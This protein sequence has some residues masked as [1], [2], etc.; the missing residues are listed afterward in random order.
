MH[1]HSKLNFDLH[2]LIRQLTDENTKTEE[3]LNKH[4]QLVLYNINHYCIITLCCLY[5]R[6]LME[7]KQ[8]QDSEN[9]SLQGKLQ[10]LEA[11][12]AILEKVYYTKLP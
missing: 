6:M 7:D 8:R 5:N 10:K 2:S 12:N 4:I 1:T 9:R 3:S 11:Q